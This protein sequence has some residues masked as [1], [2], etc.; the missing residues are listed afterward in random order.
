MSDRTPCKKLEVL[1]ENNP[2][3][4]KFCLQFLWMS[5]QTLPA[6]ILLRNSAEKS[7]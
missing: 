6:L 3:I 4:L 2:V 7:R 5:D 1:Q